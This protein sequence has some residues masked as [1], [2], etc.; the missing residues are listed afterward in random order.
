MRIKNVLSNSLS[1][2][3]TVPIKKPMLLSWD[4]QGFMIFKYQTG[5]FTMKDVFNYC[6]TDTK[7]DREFVLLPKDIKEFLDIQHYI[8]NT[9]DELIIVP[10]EYGFDILKVQD[11]GNPLLVFEQRFWSVKNQLI[12]WFLKFTPKYSTL[13]KN[14]N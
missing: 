2:F 1:R 11:N 7:Y 13:M 8:D 6:I 12:L 5:K 9:N 14:K 10:K 4:S 3:R